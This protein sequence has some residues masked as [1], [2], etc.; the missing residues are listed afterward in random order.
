[1]RGACCRAP[2][3]RGPSA[4]AGAALPDF[5]KWGA[6]ERK[7]MSGVRRTTAHRLT[8]AWN[9]VPHVFPARSRRHH[10]R[11]G[12]AQAAVEEVRSRRAGADHHHGVSDEGAGGGAEEIPADEL[13]GRS[14]D[15][16]NHLQAVRPHRRGGRHRSRAARA[17]H[18]RRRPEGHLPDRR[19]DRAGRGEGAQPEALARRHAGR[20]RSPSRT[21]AAWGPAPL[22]RS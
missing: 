21:W 20:R 16:R 10:G 12:A 6:I 13:V 7:P 8:Q 22:R 15:R 3:L 17:G 2:A 5:S 19:R 11:R 1:M 4:A 9:T 18:S 14:R